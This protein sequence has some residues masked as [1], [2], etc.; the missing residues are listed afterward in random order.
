MADIFTPIIQ[1]LHELGFFKFLLPYMLT[2]S[3]FYGL[4][5]K[6]EVFGRPEKNQAV[7]GTVALV[8]SLMVWAAPIIAGIDIETQLAAFFTQGLIMTL[9]SMVSLMIA[10][11]FLPPNLPEVLKDAMGNWV[12]A[13]III[14]IAAGIFVFLMSGLFYA[15]FGKVLISIP[16]DALWS[17]GAII[18]L[19]LP[20]ILIVGVGGGGERKEKGGK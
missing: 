18:L 2:S 6:S 9:V 16:S 5:R 1:K 4:L 20:I 19:I 15:L 17:I 3:I 7:N 10:G 8:T 11:M 13:L 14:G 12:A